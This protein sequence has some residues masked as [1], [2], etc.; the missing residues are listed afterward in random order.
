MSTHPTET[1]GQR[2]VSTKLLQYTEEGKEFICGWG[3][4]SVNIAMTFPINK[5]QFRQQLHYIS[6]KEAVRQLQKEGLIALYR[7]ILP[8]F[9]QKSANLAIMFGMY[10]KFSKVFQQRFPHVPTDINCAAAA[11]LS[12]TTEAILT[13]FERVQTVLQDRA[14]RHKFPNTFSV[15][16]AMREFGVSEYY[17]GLVPILIRNGLSNAMFFLTRKKLKAVF[18]E[19]DSAVVD[20][21]EDFVSGGILGAAISTIFYPVN[22][23]KTKMQSQIGGEFQGLRVVFW[24]LYRERQSCLRSVYRGADINVVRC[25]LSWGIINA[26]YELLL[27]WL[28]FEDT[29]PPIV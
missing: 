15:F 10:D 28:Y 18:P 27:K 21:M 13:P 26:T 12:G 16:G 6:T 5:V 24:Q 17:R 4:S 14:Y 8:P 19:T 2:M 9:L 11:I 23:C 3:A 7:G 29:S 25:L 22:V 20:S 1:S